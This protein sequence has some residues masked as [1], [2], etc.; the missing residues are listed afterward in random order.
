MI[1]VHSYIRCILYASPLCGAGFPLTIS[2]REVRGCVQVGS[3]HVVTVPL[4]ADPSLLGPL[5]TAT[6][7]QCCGGRGPV[8]ADGR[9]LIHDAAE[10]PTRAGVL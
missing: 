8:R 6:G 5:V 3:A 4:G 2:L 7:R 9:V 10:R 1:N